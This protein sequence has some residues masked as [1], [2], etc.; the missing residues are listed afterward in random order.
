M[1]FLN[2]LLGKK[3]PP[4]EETPQV[5]EAPGQA[6]EQQMLK[7]QRKEQNPK[8]PEDK[9]TGPEE[10]TIK[11]KSG[12][13]VMVLRTKFYRDGMRGTLTLCITLSVALLVSGTL[14]AY[15]FIRAQNIEREYFSVGTDGRMT[16][17]VPLNAPYMNDAQLIAWAS[18][19]ARQSFTMD[20]G[21]YRQRAGE[22]KA[23]YTD[24]GFQQYQKALKDSGQIEAI[25]RDNLIMTAAPLAVPVIVARGYT[26]GNAAIWRVRMPLRVT[27]Q[28]Q[29]KGGSI[30]LLVTMVLIRRPISESPFGVG[31]SQFVTGPLSSNEVVQ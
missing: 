13:D 28:T 30:G 8:S 19:A 1:S 25:L 29:G 10:D 2:K 5:L 7:K 14:N 9:G 4:D 15:Q 24:Y 27:Y 11:V 17:L 12:L 31:I 16:P 21:N 6:L 18:E 3:P 20:A 23:Y 26:T 22:I